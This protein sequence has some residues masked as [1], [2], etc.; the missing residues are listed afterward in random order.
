M[1]RRHFLA[2]GGA[3]IVSFRL[4]AAST[5]E[6]G[7]L[8]QGQ[9]ATKAPK[10]PGSLEKEPLLDSWIRIG[11]DNSVTVMTGKVELGQGI[12]TALIQVAA[13]ELVVDPARIAL[14]T[15]DTAA[16]PNE[17]YTAG[18]QSMSD[19]GI[20]ILHAAAQVRTIIADLAARKLGVTAGQLA[21]RDGVVSA[22]DGKRVTY[23]E[24]VSGQALHVRAEPQSALRDPLQR[25]V[26]GKSM[27]RVDIPAKLTGRPIYVH[28]FRPDGMVHARVLRPPS[29]GA[30]LHSLDDARAGKLPGVLKI[31]RNGSHV[32]VV[33]ER[34]YQA[35][36]AVRALA[37]GARWSETEALP[38]SGDLYAHLT[39]LPSERRVI[40]ERGGA[41][42]GGRTI[43]AA[44]RRPYQMHASIGPS[45]AVALA[46]DRGVTV[47]THSQGVYPLRDAL[48]EMLR[49]APE[50]VR[51]VHMEGSGCY[52]HNAADDV[53]ADA[54]LIAVAFPGR[55]VRVQWMREEEHAWEPYGSAMTSRASARI[56]DNGDVLDWQYE[57]WSHSH[58]TRPGRAGNLAPAWLIEAP[59]ELPVP[60]PIPQPT[61][62]GDRNAIPYYRLPNAR[63]V[64]HFIPE[65]TLR[66]SALRALGGYH[67]VFA[68]ESFVDEIAA[69]T[70]IDPVEW[71]LRHLDDARAR[72]VVQTAAERFGWSGY[73]RERERGRGIAFARYKNLAAYAA[74][75]LDVRVERDTGR[76]QVLRAVAA[77]D[78]GEAVNPN[79]IQNQVEG[80]VVQSLSWT[81]F[82]A[83][84]FDRRRI[85]SVDWGGYPILRFGSVP[86]RV[87]VHVIS[88][89]GQPFLGT[90]EAVHGPLAGALAN[91]IADATGVRMR[92]L[93]FTP[94][95]VRA[96]MRA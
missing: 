16:T 32:A 60:K 7:Q 2:T 33:V 34:E 8:Q 52:G 37:L 47:W 19:S 86:G 15:A 96:A 95:R 9:P 38:P 23:G 36:A 20:A 83:V 40:L 12:K 22:P 4:R 1:N 13:E 44:Y 50:R 66:T 76:V 45:C 41:P 46:N 63:I 31:A 62:G 18:S 78:S 90:G 73:R 5:L 28:D 30:R 67:N 39:S 10:L 69:A 75:A 17:S 59:F 43:E 53:A 68:V 27:A 56:A 74:V 93:P 6:E 11:A 72:D 87:D 85:T 91:A 42:G 35:V 84:A 48:A 79:G 89:P 21:L 70:R 82:E 64:H 51:C 14:V 77:I 88:R 25:A 92:E 58:N 65:M 57:V 24:L 54:A 94:Q 3:L 80:G 29:Y 49:V 55:P 26:M 71:R 81:L 61:G